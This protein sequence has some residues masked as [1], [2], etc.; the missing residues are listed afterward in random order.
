MQSFPW[1][2]LLLFIAV[3][4][5]FTPA[6]AA[7]RDFH[8]TDYLRHDWRDEVVYFPVDFQRGE[9]DGAHYQLTQATDGAPVPAQLID[10]TRYRDGSVRQV[11][12]AFRCDLPAGQTCEWRLMTGPQLPAQTA[13]APVREE[14]NVVL[15]SGPLSLLAPGGEHRYRTPIAA[16]AAPAPLLGVK[17]SDGLWRGSGRLESAER[18]TRWRAEL[19]ENGPVL[20]ALSHNLSLHRRQGLQGHLAPLSRSQLC[21]A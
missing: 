18:I 17:G 3:I 6:D 2:T 12:L 20:L 11:R 9:C 19:I 16:A 21:A 15:S 10:M 8:L 13:P 7:V 14:E 5:L 4:C 1:P